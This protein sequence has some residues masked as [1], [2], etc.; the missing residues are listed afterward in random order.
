MIEEIQMDNPEPVLS[1]ALA[2][3]IETPYMVK[4]SI[5]F[6]D[7]RLDLHCTSNALEEY[8]LTGILI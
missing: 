7:K 1:K 3:R 4:Y 5:S 6:N 8:K 2:Q